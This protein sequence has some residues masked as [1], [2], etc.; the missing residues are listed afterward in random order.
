MYYSPEK[1]TLPL[2]RRLHQRVA[3]CGQMRAG[4]LQCAVDRGHAQI[5]Q[6]RDFGCR[7]TQYLSQ[8]QHRALLGRKKLQ[9]GDEG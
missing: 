7:P 2:L 3:V 6:R 5:E 1:F 8:N 4:P 9:R